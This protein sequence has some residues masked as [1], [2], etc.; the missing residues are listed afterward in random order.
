LRRAGRPRSRAATPVTSPGT[1]KSCG[2]THT[3]SE[4]GYD[5]A[6]LRDVAVILDTDRASL[7]YCFGSKEELLQEIVREALGRDIAAAEATNTYTAIYLNG[8][9]TVRQP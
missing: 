9:G 6:T 4:P 3:Y 5:S 8:F 1:R 2:P 7:S